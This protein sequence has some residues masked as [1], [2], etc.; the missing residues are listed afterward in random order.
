MRTER[1]PGLPASW[2]FS[3]L[4]LGMVG[5]WRNLDRK[6][7]V[8]FC[9]F[10]GNLEYAVKKSLDMATVWLLLQHE[11]LLKEE[12]EKSFALL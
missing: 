9:T 2:I 4:I 5:S 7:I 8:L 12:G 6:L 1:K 10:F 3:K 11:G